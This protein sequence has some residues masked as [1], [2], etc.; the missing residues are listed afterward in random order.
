[1]HLRTVDFLINGLARLNLVVPVERHV[2]RSIAAWA[3]LRYLSH[4]AACSGGTT[5]FG[6]LQ[7][8]ARLDPIGVFDLRVEAQQRACGRPVAAG[9]L[10]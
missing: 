10:T 5:I 7:R 3:A 1:M 8:L 4:C 6:E 2:E 9:Y